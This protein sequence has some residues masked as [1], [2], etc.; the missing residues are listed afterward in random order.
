[1][2]VRRRTRN[3]SSPSEK[4]APP[5]IHAL[6]EHSVRKA[7]EAGKSAAFTDIN[8][9]TEKLTKKSVIATEQFEWRYLN[10][11]LTIRRYTHYTLEVSLDMKD[12]L[13]SLSAIFV[14][15]SD[16]H[17]EG[18]IR[19]SDAMPGLPGTVVVRARC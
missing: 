5:R 3:R 14:S 15:G 10:K 6:A 16:T 4:A 18:R 13:V 2:P 1:M 19:H 9:K 11:S 17:A 12:F 8:R 7:S